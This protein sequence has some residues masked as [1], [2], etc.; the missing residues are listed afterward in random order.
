MPL[1]EILTVGTLTALFKK[2]GS[3]RGSRKAVLEKLTDEFPGCLYLEKN[4]VAPDCQFENPANLS[5]DGRLA[6]RQPVQSFLQNHLESRKSQ[7][8]FGD[9][10]L[11]LADAGM[12][13]SS[14]LVML[15][16]HHLGGFFPQKKSCEIIKL[17]KDSLN[18][19]SSI[20]NKAHT[21]LLLDALDEDPNCF[22]RVGERIYEI[23]EATES[24]WKVI[25]S[26]RTAFIGLP[27]DEVFKNKGTARLEGYSVKITYLS[28]FS[29]EQVNEYLKRTFSNNTKKLEK[30]YSVVTKMQ[31]LAMR[32][33]LLSHIEDLIGTDFKRN[34][35]SEYEVYTALVKEW[36]SREEK[37]FRKLGLKVSYKGIFKGMSHLAARMEK[38]G[39]Q[40]F[41]LNDIQYTIVN[42]PS[43]K[44][45]TSFDLGG[46][47]LLNKNTKGHYRF[48]HRSIQEFLSVFAICNGITKDLKTDGYLN[49]TTL[50]QRFISQ[51]DYGSL[52]IFMVHMEGT[53]NS[54]LISF[55]NSVLTDCIFKECRFLNMDFSNAK[56]WECDFTGATF[57]NCN[58]QNASFNSCIFEDCSFSSNEW[59]NSEF[60]SCGFVSSKF[61]KKERTVS[62][63]FR[64]CKLDYVTM[65]N[66]VL[67]Y[68]I[69]DHCDLNNARLL[70]IDAQETHFICCPGRDAQ[71]SH[72]AL[73]QASTFEIER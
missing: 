50:M 16:M 24:F 38:L 2:L 55:T 49:L 40:T 42:N 60:D 20:T 29:D 7:N 5:Y 44:N 13:K 15:K 58:F 39:I 73:E 64:Y 57:E 10:L 18:R 65:N 43:L 70:N 17:G 61:T 33:L 63:T 11:I 25:I 9:H 59:E 35:L 19:I 62:T 48:S 37:K 53:I 8:E 52:D 46:R 22:D 6:K 56:V 1:N 72:S 21:L 51:A 47:S 4:F 12:G 45:I 36:L 27:T 31:S 54:S 23:L 28:P 34:D 14:L 71:F 67:D 26:C 41:E 69:F 32:P 66:T 30:A 3:L 68:S